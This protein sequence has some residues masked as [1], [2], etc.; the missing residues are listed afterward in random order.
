VNKAHSFRR[1]ILICIATLIATPVM[2]RDWRAVLIDSLKP[3]DIVFRR[4]Q[5]GI[6]ETI[7][8]AQQWV[9]GQKT[10]WTHAGI[11]H[12]I[13]PG[14][15][16]YIIHA[17]E[18]GVTLDTP[19]AFF[20]A[21]EALAGTVMSGDTRLAHE[22]AQLLGRPFDEAFVESDGGE[23]VYCTELVTLAAD[24]AGIPIPVK[25]R[26]MP[27]ALREAVILPDDLAEALLA[28]NELAR[29]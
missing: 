4:G 14:G 21:T 24:A 10:R 20:S 7:A 8:T 27:V 19:A 29:K 22:A 5:G 26:M 13:K 16:I 18:R 11:V 15:P 23:R 25:R 9:R 1:L 17:V 6:S 12:Q 3:G 2:A 28:R